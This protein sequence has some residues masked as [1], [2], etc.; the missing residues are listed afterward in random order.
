MGE[1]GGDM[2][3]RTTVRNRSAG[4]CGKDWA[5]MVRPLPAEPTKRRRLDRIQEKSQNP[6]DDQGSLGRLIESDW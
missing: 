1:R 4:R 2:Q 6:T 3:Q 5:L